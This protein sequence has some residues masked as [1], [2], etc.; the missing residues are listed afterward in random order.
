STDAVN[1]SQLYTTNQNVAT[2]AAN[3]STYLGGGA[4]VAN[5][6]APTYNV[7]GGSY[8]N[9]GSAISAINGNLSKVNNGSVGIVQRT[10]NADET[11]LTASGG[12][13]ANPG[14]AQ[15]LTNLAAGTVS[16]SSNDAINGSQLSGVS[17]SVAKALGGGATVNTN[18]SISAPSY[19]IGAGRYNNAG[20]AFAA[21]NTSLNS[22]NNGGG[23]KYFHANSQAADSQANGTNSIAV[24]PAAIASGARSIAAGSNALAK[25]DNA[26]AIGSNA[27]ATNA[28]DVALGSGSVTQSA[29][30]TSSMTVNGHSYSVAGKATSTVSVGDLGKERTVTNVAGGRVSR[31]S[32]DAVNGSQLWATNQE[33]A[34]IGNQVTTIGAANK[35]AL[36]YDTDGNGNR[37]NSVTLQGGDPNAPVLVANVAA[38]K[39]DTDAVNYRQLKDTAASTLTTANSYT[40][41]RTASAVT[42]AKAYTDSSSAKTLSAANTYTD[43]RFGM[44]SSSIGQVRTEARQ[45]AA[46]GLAAGSLRYDARPGKVSAAIGGGTWRG[47]GAFAMGLGFTNEDQS[48]SGNVSATTAGGK[49]GVGAGLSFTLN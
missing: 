43:Q 45:A 27:V 24:G 36:Q 31:D 34:A 48:V 2:A 15:K 7:A 1:G 35:N 39:V 37:K 40:D 49:W 4:N 16:A 10:G 8:N 14:N 21:V 33:I 17:E 18:G 19:Q 28:G 41:V 44:L 13:A 22:I 12:T 38:G 25:T 5:G 42:T 29:V 26:L 46:I 6:T 9:V 47:Q 20:D 11:V 30:Q 23:I 32:T 3:T